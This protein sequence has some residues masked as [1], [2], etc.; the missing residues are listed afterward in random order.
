MVIYRSQGYAEASE[1]LLKLK[2]QWYDSNLISDVEFCAAFVLIHLEVAFGRDWLGGRMEKISISSRSDLPSRCRL[3]CNSG[4][5]EYAKYLSC[6]SS[7]CKCRQ[8]NLRLC[9]FLP[10]EGIRPTLNKEAFVIDIFEGWTLKRMPILVNKCIV[11]WWHGN[12]TA[13][14]LFRLP[15]A[16]EV[17]E[18]MSNGFRVISLL[19]AEKALRE[20]YIDPYEPFEQRDNLSFSIHDMQHLERFNDV[21]FWE[22]Q[23]GLFLCLQ[24]NLASNKFGEFPCCQNESFRHD[25]FHVISDMNAS[26]VHMLAFWKAKWMFSY[27][28]HLK[29]EALTE[30]ESAFFQSAFVDFM[31][32]RVLKGFEKDSPFLRECFGNLCNKQLF[33]Q[34]HGAFLVELFRRIGKQKILER[35]RESD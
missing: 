8:K 10:L 35:K 7:S 4:D 30:Q 12:R 11:E 21:L 32:L 1:A 14:L 3:A 6:T 28:L 33:L 31:V 29:K 25:V 24:V 9:D 34:C 5:L 18:M 27:K 22:E 2:A 20:I 15:S 13:I 19:L 23:V 17:L 26:V 16:W